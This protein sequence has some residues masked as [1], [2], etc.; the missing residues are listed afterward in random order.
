VRDKDGAGEIA[1]KYASF[2]DLDR[3]LDIIL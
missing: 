3:I 2:D 1:I